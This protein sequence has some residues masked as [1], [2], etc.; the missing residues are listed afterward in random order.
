MGGGKV[1]NQMECPH[2]VG[3]LFPGSPDHGRGRIHISVDRLWVKWLH[4]CID[5]QQHL[6][7]WGGRVRFTL[8]LGGYQC[9]CLDAMDGETLQQKKTHKGRKNC[10][11]QDHQTQES[12]GKHLLNLIELIQGT[13]GFHGVKAKGCQRRCVYMCGA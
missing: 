10:Q 8:L 6:N 9:L 5:F 7:H 2:T 3:L 13:I 12:G 1:Q 11:L 4:R